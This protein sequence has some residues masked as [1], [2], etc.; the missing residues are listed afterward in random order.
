MNYRG[1][2][3]ADW[4]RRTNLER[5]TPGRHILQSGERGVWDNVSG[6]RMP[7][8]SESRLFAP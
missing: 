6:K 1:I 2:D 3:F 4:N 7:I 5:R 8:R